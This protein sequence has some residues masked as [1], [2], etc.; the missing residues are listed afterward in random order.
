MHISYSE[1]P[2][3]KYS[4]NNK[5]NFFLTIYDVSIRIIN[6]LGLKYKYRNKTTTT[7]KKPIHISL[8]V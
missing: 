4:T 3:L 2:K 1:T 8:V 7:K 5:Q 6:M